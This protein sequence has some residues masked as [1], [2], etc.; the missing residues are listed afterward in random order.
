VTYE[1][2]DGAGENYLVYGGEIRVEPVEGIAV[3]Y[4]E[5]RSDASRDLDDRRTVRA[6][7]AEADLKGWG[8]VQVELAQTENNLGE[9]GN[10]A[11]VSY[12][13]TDEKHTVRAE[14]ARTDENFDAPNS[15]VNAGRE[16]VRITTQHVVTERIGVSTDALYTR[17]SETGERRT[18]AEVKG[19]YAVSPELD[20]I[21][22]G[23]VVE[24]RRD[25]DRNEVVSG[26][27]G[28]DYRPEFIPGASFQAEYEQDFKEN[29]N[30][31][32]T[33][34]GDY[35][36][37]PNLRFYALNE[38]SSADTGFFGLGDG[39]DTNFTTRVGAEYQVTSAVSGY[40][41]YRQSAGVAA[42]G[43]VANGFR[44]QWDVTEHLAMRLGAEH[45]EPLKDGDDRTS[46]VALGA[47]YEN[48]DLG[49]IWRNDVEVDRDD[50]G[51]GVY[52][53]TAVGYELDKDL[54]VLFR[55]R[56]AIDLRDDDRL[57][58]RLRFG[59]AWRPERDTRIKT[60]ALYEYE[61]DDDNDVKEQA[62]RWS[63]GG[64]YSPS[65]DWRL[66]AKY[67]GEHVDFEGPGFG[68]S[69][70]LHLARGG[71]EYDFAE[72]DLGRDRFAIGGHVALFTDNAGDDV[73]AGVGVELKANVIE[74]VQIAVGFNH[75][76]VEEERL[77]DLYHSGFYLR[78]RLKLDDSV[79]DH[80]DQTGITSAP[81]LYGR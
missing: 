3:G 16:E 41:E 53:N 71:I 45:V 4:R 61:I 49:L 67:A 69:S 75:I 7:Y 18:G 54:T 46:S 62:H 38:I 11:R 6:A 77:R 37:N 2:E 58:D 29:D 59:L 5:V 44:G 42:D 30:W 64:T 39:A 79:W 76:D 31:R 14:A 55:N 13:Y 20:L 68:T 40:S 12:E 43:G 66:D 74:N 32:L 60:L 36:W 22:G 17:D 28:A 25:D 23:R 73:T 34:G 21:A 56:L 81:N 1:N 10:A 26:I 19:R 63:F 9:E 57:R 51:M 72:D 33:L 47:S 27:V 70:T 65:E 48:D 80:F 50:R 24:T 35:Q 15:Y 8:K 78:L 52:T